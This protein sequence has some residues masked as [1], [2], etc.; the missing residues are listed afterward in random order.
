[1]SGALDGIRVVDL[2]SVLM[3]PYATQILGDMGADVIKVEPPGGDTV[4]GIGPMR[5][6]G[7]G[8][9]FLHV[10]RNKRSLVLDLKKAAG[11]EAFFR[12][13]ASADVVIYNIRPQAMARLGISYDELRARNE[14]LIYVGVYGFGEDGPYAGKPAY[15]D[16]IQG[17]A[18]VPALVARASGEEPRYVPLTLADRTVGLAAANAVLAALLARARTGRGQRVEVPMFETMTQFVLG[19]H[20]GGET[21]VPPLGATGYP[22]LLAPERRPYRTRDGYI[23][24]LIY[25][26]KQWQRFLALIGQAQLF[27]ADPRFASIGARTQHINELYAIVGQALAG[28]SSG[29]WL[30]LLEA[31]DI[32]AMP[33]NDV[34]S[35]IKDEHLRATGFIKVVEH[36]SEGQIRQIG[37]PAQFSDSASATEPRPAPRLGQHSHEILAAIGYGEEQIS[38]LFAEHVSAGDSPIQTE[39]RNA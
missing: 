15:D 10:N 29:E 1:M 32:P 6:P 11:L 27:T 2:T 3:G 19:E 17:A 39:G 5:N 14:R 35:L 31:A 18:A 12:L 24:V 38:R 7:M 4:R 28:K 30:A 21:F 36:P 9:I 20:M 22:R 25:S 26:D 23:C 8:H 16:L 33:L 37:I 34:E 13:A